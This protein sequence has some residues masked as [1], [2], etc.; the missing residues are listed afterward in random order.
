MSH[1][2]V[3]IRRLHIHLDGIVDAIDARYEAIARLNGTLLEDL[4]ERDVT[5]VLGG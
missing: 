2:T 3:S 1:R 4:P 5:A